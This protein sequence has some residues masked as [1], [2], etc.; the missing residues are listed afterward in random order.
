LAT[1]V[2]MYMLY[3]RMVLYQRLPV[4]MQRQLVIIT[5]ERPFF[6]GTEFSLHCKYGV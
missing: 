5:M 3:F 1:T 4:C 6:H 2:Y